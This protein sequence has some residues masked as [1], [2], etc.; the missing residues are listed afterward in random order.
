MTRATYNIPSRNLP[1]L[2]ELIERLNKRAR[3][4]GLPEITVTETGHEDREIRNEF[5]MV[6]GTRRIH[7]IELAGDDPVLNGWHFVATLQHLHDEENTTILRTVPGG[8]DLPT[9]YRSADPRNCDHCHLAIWRRDTYL[10]RN[11]A[12]AYRQVGSTCLGDFL[13]HADPHAMAACAEIW[14]AAGEAARGAEDEE[15]AGEGGH[16]TPELLNLEEFLA[17]T[18]ASIEQDGWTSRRT[19]YEMGGCS[20]S[21]AV[22]FAMFPPS[23]LSREEREALAHPTESHRAKAT[24]AAEW[25]ASLGNGSPDGLSD[26]LYN[27]RALVL[28]GVIELRNAGLAASIAYSHARGMGQEAD[29][30]RQRSSEYIGQ[31]KDKISFEGT[32]TLALPLESGYGPCTLVKFEAGGN[33]VVWFASGSP[34]LEVGRTYTMKAT[35]KKH[36]ERDGVKQTV[37]TRAKCLEAAAAS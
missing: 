26:Y 15:W 14:A 25:A 1:K 4:L 33:V 30:E 18:F 28:S 20:T 34:D 12:G 21:D 19:A 16:R 32:V 37:V 5:G 23:Q 27:V 3:R 6:V 31:P 29:L 22:I 24:A 7:E 11:E 9:Q 2:Q 36:D 10:L 17:Y 8:E 13:G 35:V